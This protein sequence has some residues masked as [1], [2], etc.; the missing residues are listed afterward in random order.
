MVAAVVFFPVMI[1]VTKGLTQVERGHLELLASYAASPGRV[2]RA[3]RVPNALPYLFAALE[4]AAS[5]AVIAAIVTEY[6]GGP[7]EARGV[8]IA[9]QAGLFRFTEA[10]AA[11]VAAA[12]IGLGLYALVLVAE[13]LATPWQRP[14]S[15]RAR[16]PAPPADPARRYRR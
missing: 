7:R 2:T 10:W 16:R 1:N 6:F 12:A 5:L 9:Q 3:V 4:V 15:R 14:A 8:Y 13:R 11:V